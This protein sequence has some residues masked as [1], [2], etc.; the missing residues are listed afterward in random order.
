MYT[1]A[2]KYDHAGRLKTVKQQITGDTV[3]IAENTYN[4]LGQLIKTR[5]HGGLDSTAYTYNIR[6]WLKTIEGKFSQELNYNE[7]GTNSLSIVP[8]WGGNIS[9]MKWKAPTTANPNYWHA[10]TFE[11]DNL[12][13]LKEG[14]YVT[15][16][17]NANFGTN[18]DYYTEN[19]DYDVMGNIK[20]LKRH[21]G[22]TVVETSHTY[23]GN[24]LGGTGSGGAPG[25]N[26]MQ[27]HI[28]MNETPAPG[29]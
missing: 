7:A 16:A 5:L 29:I 26:T 8:Q 15:N 1:N 6:G 12:S 9:A 23:H 25:S 28:I 18:K 4:A 11:Y 17:G 27:Q 19:Y 20:R 3:T 13:R 22:S 10:Y 14:N 2:N 24:R 21:N